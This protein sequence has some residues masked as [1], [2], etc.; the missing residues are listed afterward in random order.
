[1]TMF[2]GIDAFSDHERHHA[3]LIDRERSPG[4]GPSTGRTRHRGQMTIHAAL[5]RT[6]GARQIPDVAGHA[7]L[8][9][10]SLDD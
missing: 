8:D 3:T 5:L 9:A 2:E 7:P 1:M 10:P 4:A 6:G